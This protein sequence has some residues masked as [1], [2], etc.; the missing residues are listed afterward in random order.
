MLNHFGIASAKPICTPLTAS[1]HLSE[2]YTTK[3]ELEKEYMFHVP[4]ASVVGSLM[5]AIVCTRPNLAQAISIV[6][7][8]MGNP[9]KVH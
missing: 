5:Y 4:Y 9:E 1:I 2:L 3:L 7:R 8:Y 6:S